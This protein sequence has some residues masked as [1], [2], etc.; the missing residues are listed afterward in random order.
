MER[1]VFTSYNKGGT[2][3]TI[4]EKNSPFTQISYIADGNTK[5]FCGKNCWE[6]T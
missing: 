1:D 3:M 2:T 5:V 6:I 4:G